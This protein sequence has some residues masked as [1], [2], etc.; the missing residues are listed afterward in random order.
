MW[1]AG[2]STVRSHWS[3]RM[4]F[5]SRNYNPTGL[6]IGQN[7]VELFGDVNTVSG[8]TAG[9]I[10]GE[11]TF[12]ELFTHHEKPDG[13]NYALVRVVCRWPTRE[14]RVEVSFQ[15]RKNQRVDRF[16]D[17]VL[18]SVQAPLKHIFVE[19]LK[20]AWVPVVRHNLTLNQGLEQ[21]PTPGPV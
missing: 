17:L 20:R 18:L 9:C 19:L 14:Y 11:L 3:V 13:R 8:L 4:S 16:D 7:H 5:G 6:H 21:A 1:P 15:D 12:L 10:R 2:S